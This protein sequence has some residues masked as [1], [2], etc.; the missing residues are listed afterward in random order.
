MASPASDAAARPDIEPF[1]PHTAEF[2]ANPYATYRYYRERDPVHPGTPI[3]STTPGLW[4]LFRYADIAEALKDN[5]LGRETHRLAPSDARPPDPEEHRPFKEMASNF[6]LFRDPPT[7][8]RLRMLVNRAF[9]PRT[10]EKR[11]ASIAA[12]ADELVDA[13]APAGQMDLITDFAFQL[14]VAVIVEMLGVRIEDRTKFRE[15]AGRIAAAV[16]VRTSNDALIPASEATLNL[17]AYLD[18]IIDERRLEPQDDL[19]SQLVAVQD[20]EGPERLSDDEM[21]ATCVLLLIAGH[22]TTTNLIGNG[23]LALL[24]HREQWDALLD[25]QAEVVN[26]V[27]ELVRYDSPVQMTFRAAF[28]DLAIG[29]QPIRRGEMIGM[30]LGSANRDPE[31]YPDPERLDVTRKPDVPASFGFGIH[32]CLGAGLA[33]LEGQVAFETL[34]RRLPNLQLATD[35]PRWRPNIAFRGLESLPVTF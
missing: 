18:E 33:R 2:S 29:D 35:M 11:R 5:R 32:F 4:Y 23:T 22:E 8:T 25:G 6:M 15:W 10:V 20:Q 28:E 21:I 27:E 3:L 12:I 16:D 9:T 13:V 19:I 26:A 34:L 14:P 7:H 31:R 30:V 24:Q 1:N 17:T